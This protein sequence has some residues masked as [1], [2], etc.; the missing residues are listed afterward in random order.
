MSTFLTFNEGLTPITRLR[1]H[2]HC[3]ESRIND[4]QHPQQRNHHVSHCPSSRTC[5]RVF[6]SLSLCHSSHC[7]PNSATSSIEQACITGAYFLGAKSYWLIFS[8]CRPNLVFLPSA[9]SHLQTSLIYGLHALMYLRSPSS[10]GRSSPSLPP[11]QQ[12]SSSPPTQAQ[13]FDY[14]LW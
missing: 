8:H 7:Y 12:V 3:Q 9:R 10:F 2:V 11:V 1:I 14:G 6:Y 5:F 13:L 4:L